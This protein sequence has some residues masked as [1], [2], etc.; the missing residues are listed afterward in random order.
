MLPKDRRKIH[1]SEDN[2]KMSLLARLL[3]FLIR[4]NFFP[5]KADF[6]KM[7]LSF[8]FCSWRSIIFLS[9]TFIIMGSTQAAQ[10][11]FSDIYFFINLKFL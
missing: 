2:Q 5:L 1:P 4:I 9:F 11:Q 8:A 6:D 7:K 3:R 10:G